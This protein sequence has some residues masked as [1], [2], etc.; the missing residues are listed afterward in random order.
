[1]D[2]WRLANQHAVAGTGRSQWRGWLRKPRNI[3]FKRALEADCGSTRGHQEPPSDWDDLPRSRCRDRN[4]KQHR[5]TQW[6]VK[7]WKQEQRR[8]ALRRKRRR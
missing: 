4:W 1:M 3:G 8:V 5:K 6:K 7:T 2:G